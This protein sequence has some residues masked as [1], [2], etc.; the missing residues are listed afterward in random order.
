MGVLADIYISRNED[1]IKYDAAP[2]QFPDRAEYK[3]LTPHELSIL[4][5]IIRGIEWEFAMIDE[6]PCL[7]QVNRGE[8]LIHRIPGPMASELASLSPDR[9][10][11]ITSAWAATEELSCSPEDIKPVVD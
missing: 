9:I 8:R 3:H 1:A 11:S 2:H 6:F 5:S 4:W 10:A 7:L